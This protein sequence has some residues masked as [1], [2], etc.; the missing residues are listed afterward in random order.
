MIPLGASW[1]IVKN[2][3]MVDGIKRCTN[4][5]RKHSNG[6]A[7]SGVDSLPIGFIFSIF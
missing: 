6:F 4:T 3:R 7:L 1:A 2:L 5:A